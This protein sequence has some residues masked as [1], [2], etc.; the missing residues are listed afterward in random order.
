MPRFFHF[1]PLLLIGLPGV[2]AEGV[3]PRLFFDAAKVPE[4]RAKAAAPE[5]RQIVEAI[6]FMRD[7]GDPFGPK[8]HKEFGNSAI[9]YLATGERADADRAR[10][11]M[12]HYI[13]QTDIWAN[14]KHKG[15]RR[16]ALAR[17]GAISY[18][19]CFDAWKGQTVPAQVTWQGKTRDVPKEYVGMDLNGAMSKA[20]LAMAR[21]LLESGGADWPGGDKFGNNWYG[22]RYGSAALALLASDEPEARELLPKAEQPL[23]RYIETSLGTHAE[24]AGWNP[25]GYG[26]TLYPA[27]FT[28]PAI[29]A[30]RRLADPDFVK[31]VPAVALNLATVYHGLLALPQ[32]NPGFLGLHPDFQDDNADFLGEG[33][34]NLAFAF[35]PDSVKPALKWIYN[36]SFGALGDQRY[37]ATSCGGLYALL[38]YPTDLAEKNPAETE[39]F[40]RTLA[41]R[42]WGFVS[43]RKAFGEPAGQ[44]IL[45]QF[46]VKTAQTDGGHNGPDG[47][48]FRIWGLGVPW[49]T[50]SGRTIKPA[51]QCTVFAGDPD[52]AAY[53]S[54]DHEWLDS[55]IR[56]S[57]GGFVVGRARPFSDVG[58]KDH[59]RR[60]IADYDPGTDAEAAFVVADTSANGKFWRLNTPGFGKDGDYN[61]ITTGGNTFTVTNSA[62]GD[63]L[64]GTVLH[65]AKPAF[66]TG[67][68]PRGSAMSAPVG[69]RA[70]EVTH[71][72]WVD[73]AHPDNG[74]GGFVVALTLLRKGAP[75]PPTAF[76]GTPENG[77]V[78]IGSRTYRIEGNR[79]A[80]PGWERPLVSI[81]EPSGDA[82]FSGAPVALTLRG[83]ASS[84]AGVDAVE[85]RAGG[86]LLGTAP[87]RDGKWSFPTPPLERGLVRISVRAKD[88]VGGVGE[89]MQNVRVT[90]TQ[91][92]AV[93]IRPPAAGTTL[94]AG[95]EL[96]LSGTASD[97]EGKP[98]G[99]EVFM[100]DR[101]IGKPPVGADGTWSVKLPAWAVSAGKPT[102]R[103]VATDGDGDTA[104]SQPLEIQFTARFSDHPE[105]GDLANWIPASSDWRADILDDNGNAR[106]RVLPSEGY[107]K[108]TANS[109]IANRTFEGDF[110]ISFHARMLTPESVL[111][112]FFGRDVY[113]RL[114]GE[115]SPGGMRY[116]GWGDKPIGVWKAPFFTDQ[117]WH[118]IELV[119][120]GNTLTLRR[121]GRDFW[122]MTLGDDRSFTDSPADLVAWDMTFGARE[123]Y[124]WYVN[125]WAPGPVG[126]GAAFGDASTF[127]MDDFL[128]GEKP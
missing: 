68:F 110:V 86:Q 96:T 104:G 57:G 90:A 95:Q 98:V 121:D 30:I 26:Y 84:P 47:L 76:K 31:N 13:A 22:V 66:R 74:D 45:T 126:I 53:K 61:T 5:G 27:Q 85:I 41:D 2:A 65:P 77:T 12:L 82:S 14:P 38:F 20:L 100:G 58:T 114:G 46:M 80:V 63:R 73:I 32:K 103:A 108:R 23:R 16:G 88:A 48:G 37:D 34:A 1:L 50:G 128:V 99:V 54:Q 94:P 89:A 52:S 7:G 9:L 106:F 109:L 75:V 69:G 11:E 55:D 56:S 8:F 124:R 91:P 24:P 10:D 79:V 87:V 123:K 64:V 29:L 59:T 97:P 33:A 71:N 40:G 125:F 92:P 44:D 15:L 119:R 49:T 127:L 25:E 117:N 28:F 43:L 4:I 70:V 102:F 19:L 120:K 6:R 17:G 118:K 51:G 67:D 93:A 62:T 105:F 116:T 39:G 111:N 36:R 112:I 115:K 42:E 78:T 122:T 113:L 101:G 72:R 18:D 35:A 21:S 3:H 83:G 60:Y 107:K 81:S